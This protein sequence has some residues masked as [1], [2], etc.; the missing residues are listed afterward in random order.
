MKEEYAY[1]LRI[2][3]RGI[4]FKFDPKTVSVSPENPGESTL[5][6]RVGKKVIPD[7]YEVQ[8]VGVDTDTNERSEPAVLTIRVERLTLPQPPSTI[9]L[10]TPE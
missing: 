3:R 7:E 5:T 9:P 2:L 1:R 6:I 10:P 8:I 4:T